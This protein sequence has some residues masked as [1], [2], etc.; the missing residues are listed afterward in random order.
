MRASDDDCGRE[1]AVW[2][3][4]LLDRQPAPLGHAVV[5][6]ARDG[7][8][9]A[10]LMRDLTSNLITGGPI[11]PLPVATYERVVDALVTFHI[12]YWQD[13]DLGD[14]RLGLCTL[15]SYFALLA[16]QRAAAI[17]DAH[18]ELR[19]VA[20]GWQLLP[21]V[22]DADVVALL[23]RLHADPQPLCDA[24]AR[25]PRTLLHGDYKLANLAVQAGKA[26]EVVLLDWALAAIGPPAVDLAWYLGTS[27]LRSPATKD[28][29]IARYASFLADAG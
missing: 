21:S 19:F 18:D 20:E 2:R 6:A 27:A 13:A 17:A 9:W 29:T 11:D 14:S 16:P 28:A 10:L 3:T 15:P 25:F 23:R 1:V 4:G 24:L 7:A 22:A 12:A 8:G 26:L 5:A